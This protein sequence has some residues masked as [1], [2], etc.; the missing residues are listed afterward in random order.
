MSLAALYNTASPLALAAV[1]AG[2]GALALRHYRALPAVQALTTGSSGS[3]EETL[4]RVS[5]VVPA[6]DEERNLPALLRSLAALDYPSYEVIVVDDASTDATGA[7]AEE[8]AARTNGL[9]RVLHGTGPEP[10]WTG[11]NFACAL[12]ARA[13]TGEW[14]L[15]TDADTEH[16]PASLRVAVTTA[17]QSRA[18]AVSLFTR[19]RCLTFWERLLLPFAYQQYFVGVRPEGLLRPGGPALANGQ[20]FLIARDAYEAAGGHAAVAASIIDDVALAG[21]LKQAGYPPLACQGESLVA[22]RMYDGLRSL[23]EGFTKNSFSFLQEQRD[24]GALVILST[25]C[26]AGVAPALIG[27]A[28]RGSGPVA[29]AGGI[30]AY[31]AQVALL[32]PWVRRFGVGWGYALL[33]P[34]AA[35]AFTGIALSSALHTL[36]RRPVRW[37][38]RGYQAAERATVAAGERAGEPVDGEARH[39]R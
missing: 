38:G 4:P 29:L 9:V 31:V 14:L 26:A 30:A 11:K 3:E 6:R 27:T 5:I 20:Y 37:K 1:V 17:V 15:F 33:A 39:V 13:A 35:L 36:A 2:A 22:V 10:G 34:L 21:A 23:A 8:E 28:L 25:A 12:G 7:L 24:K 32:A 18:R 16:A 19:Q